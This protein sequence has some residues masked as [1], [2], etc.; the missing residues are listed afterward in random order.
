MTRVPEHP[1][2]QGSRTSCTERRNLRGIS[3]AAVLQLCGQE[4]VF[5]VAQCGCSH[6]SC[7]KGL[8]GLGAAR[9]RQAQG[10]PAATRSAGSWPSRSCSPRSDEGQRHV[11]AGARDRQG[12]LCWRRPRGKQLETDP[13]RRKLRWNPL[14]R[15]CS[16]PSRSST[17]PKAWRKPCA[18][19]TLRPIVSANLDAVCWYS[20]AAPLLVSSDISA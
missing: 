8:S 20:V 5:G 19:R 3:L 1:D 16:E 11:A 17:L 9:P 10:M 14:T 7:G 4:V 6:K 12:Q 2:A 13:C 15:C 18:A